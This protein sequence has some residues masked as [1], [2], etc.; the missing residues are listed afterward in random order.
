MKTLK[1]L[2]SIGLICLTT[3][4]LP[5][6]LSLRMCSAQAQQNPPAGEPIKLLANPEADKAW[7]EAQ[8]ASQSPAPRPE[9]REKR[10][11]P[12]EVAEY[13]RPL[14]VKAADALKDFYTRFPNHPK[15]A[16]ARKKEYAL[17]NQAANGMGD[18]T[19]GVRI[20]LLEKSRM[21]DP[22]LSAEER[23]DL[24]IAALKRQVRE[25]PSGTT[26]ALVA[27]KGLIQ[28]FPA[29][30]EPYQLLLLVASSLDPL[31]QTEIA[32]GIAEGNGPEAVKVAARG[33]LKKAESLGKPLDIQ[34][35]ALDG[36]KVELA[37]LKGKVVLVDF[38]A[39]WC[40]PCVAEMPH[41]KAAYAKLHDQGFEI[42]GISF[43][44][45]KEALE[46]FVAREKVAWPQYFDGKGWQNKYG[47][48]YGIQGIPTMWLVD[49]KG[50]L[51]DL[52][53]RGQLEE[54]VARLLAQ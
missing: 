40:N 34:F 26:N 32:R 43:D 8:R 7:R 27:A 28:D 2:A 46:K 15:A 10:P 37:A 44:E 22:K 14:I 9:W 3:G 18:T 5:D 31:E 38:W 13:Y 42:V 20:S 16:E 54:K 11:T 23:Y 41:V 30:P 45:D 50:N 4:G 21:D 17:L 52:E 33:L 6:L 51:A 12:E 1:L 47:E 49:K 53:A 35:T 19:L 29:K 39:T 24:R 25:L 48:L 36:R